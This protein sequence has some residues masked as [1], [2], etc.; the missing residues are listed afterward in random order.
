MYLETMP[1]MMWVD[2]T[3]ISGNPDQYRSRAAAGNCF[4]NRLLAGNVA[5]MASRKRNTFR[6][7]MM[8]GGV[9]Q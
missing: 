7:D 9:V 5:E 1:R 6:S 8:K 4:V 2:S 3:G